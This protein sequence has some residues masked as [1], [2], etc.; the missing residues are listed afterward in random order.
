MDVVASD[1]VVLFKTSP[2]CY[3]VLLV[4]VDVITRFVFLNP[5]P[6]KS[7]ASV[8]AVLFGIYFETLGFLE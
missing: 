3:N 2:E 8:T 7:A 4:L 6:D 1:T 5:H